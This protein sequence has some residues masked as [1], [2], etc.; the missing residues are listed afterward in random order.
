MIKSNSTKLPMKS[1]RILVGLSVIVLTV[2]GGYAGS[3]MWD[4]AHILRPTSENESAFFRSYSPQRVI[5]QFD[6]KMGSATSRS[7]SRGG[8]REFVTHNA[9]ADCQFAMRSEKWMPFMNALRDD[10][11][12][13]LLGNGTQILSQS[14]DPRDGFQFEYKLGKSFGTLKVSPLAIDYGIRRITPLPGSVEDV[15]A[16][17]E[18]TEKWFPKQPGIIAININTSMN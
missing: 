17:I 3:V 6:A 5:E 14:G 8:G 16:R 2:I 7:I 1:H 12:A 18:Q 4:Q 11:S 10:V 13:Q 15:T 9:T